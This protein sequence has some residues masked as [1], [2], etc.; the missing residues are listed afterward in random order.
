MASNE[1]EGKFASVSWCLEDVENA[2]E[3]LGFE[4]TRDNINSALLAC[5]NQEK[6]IRGIMIEAG[7]ECIYQIIEDI[8]RNK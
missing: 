3:L 1:R 7:W 6:A 2:L 8:M 4:S 5:M